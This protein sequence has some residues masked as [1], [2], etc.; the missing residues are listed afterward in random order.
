MK[1]PSIIFAVLFVLFSSSS[2]AFASSGS[3]TQIACEIVN[4]WPSDFAVGWPLAIKKHNANPNTVSASGYMNQLVEI[5]KSAFKISDK[6]SLNILNTYE[7][8][9]VSLERDYINNHGRLPSKPSSSKTLLP[10]QKYCSKF[11]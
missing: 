6:N 2:S 5:Y 8:Y 9:W 1:R 11:H 10:L 4:R 7:S 3:Q